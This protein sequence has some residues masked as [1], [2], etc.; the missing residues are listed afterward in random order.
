[1]GEKGYTRNTQQC[2]VKR[3]EL[4]QVYQK[5]REAN[6][7]SGAESYTCRFYNELPAILRDDPTSTPTSNTDISQVC[8]SRENKEDDMV[9]EKEEE[10][11]RQASGGS[12][13]L[14]ARKYFKL[15]AL[16]VAGHHGGQP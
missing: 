8:E 7:C 15:G 9:D 11:G 14:K 12:I 13:S 4:R 1:M 3:K 2:H 16:W 5:A 10:N 6:S